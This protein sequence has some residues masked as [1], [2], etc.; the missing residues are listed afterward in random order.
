MMYASTSGRGSTVESDVFSARI[1]TLQRGGC[2][3][4][5]AAKT[6]RVPL[7][8]ASQ[9]MDLSEVVF[10]QKT[11]RRL[12]IKKADVLPDAS[13]KKLGFDVYLWREED[14]RHFANYH[15]R[16]GVISPLTEEEREAFKEHEEALIEVIE[17]LPPKT[18]KRR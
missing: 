1:T 8:V 6:V 5:A 10:D 3:K 11:R 12:R 4:F 18:K 14:T 2:V 9:I 15:A 16:A 13:D 7:K 17:G